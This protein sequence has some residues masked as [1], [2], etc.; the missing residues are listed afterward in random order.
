MRS[1]AH[2]PV[3]LQALNTLVLAGIMMWFV[4]QQNLLAPSALKYGP[5]DVAKAMN[6]QPRL[7]PPMLDPE[8]VDITMEDPQTFWDYW[9]HH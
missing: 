3:T 2:P 6:L 1:T 7:P 9:P 5:T 8:Q 4:A